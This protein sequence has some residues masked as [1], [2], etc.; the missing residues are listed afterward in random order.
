MSPQNFRLKKVELFITI[1]WCIWT[2]R[3]AETHAKTPK[4]ASCIL[5]FAS[6]YLS[7]YKQALT[8]DSKTHQHVS[9]CSNSQDT[10][11]ASSSHSQ[12]FAGANNAISQVSA[13]L[14][15]RLVPPNKPKWLAPPSGRLKLNTN[16]AVN[17]SSGVFG[18]GALLRNSNGDVIVAMAKPKGVL[19]QKKWKH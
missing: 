5:Q 19:N 15:H 13:T 18:L 11:A 1:R 3:N 4:S 9:G 2:E 16:A 7:D 12:T 6:N 8:S 10:A 14:Q 17:V